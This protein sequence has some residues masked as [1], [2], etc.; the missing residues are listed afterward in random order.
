MRR[1][2]WGSDTWEAGSGDARERGCGAGGGAR[3]PRRDAGRGGGRGVGVVPSASADV[4]ELGS[5]A[6]DKELEGLEAGKGSR[7]ARQ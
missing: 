1:K 4:S 2:A 3:D 7:R 6:A 5:A